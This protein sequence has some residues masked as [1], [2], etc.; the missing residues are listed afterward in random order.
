MYNKP[1]HGKP[2]EYKPTGQDA[3]IHTHHAGVSWRSFAPISLNPKTRVSAALGK[4]LSH[5]T[6]STPFME[7]AG[8]A[9]ETEQCRVCGEH[10]APSVR[11]HGADTMP[12]SGR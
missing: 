4:E 12:S 11:L 7:E 6:G 2:V 10:V 9:D 1:L 3:P 5:V 8:L